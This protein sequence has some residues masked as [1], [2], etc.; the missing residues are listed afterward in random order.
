[1][2]NNTITFLGCG[3]WGAALG[4]VLEKKGLNRKTLK[5]KS[6]E[7]C[8]AA[9]KRLIMKEAINPKVPYPKTPKRTLDPFKLIEF[10]IFAKEIFRTPTLFWFS[11]LIKIY[12]QDKNN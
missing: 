3:S 4:S 7:K 6:F 11:L 1:M 8:A 10:V 5:N 9:T 2:L 12:I